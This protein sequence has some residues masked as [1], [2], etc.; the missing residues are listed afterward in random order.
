[1]CI[2]TLNGHPRNT[3]IGTNVLGVPI[4]QKTSIKKCPT[5]PAGRPLVLKMDHLMDAFQPKK[6]SVIFTF[7]VPAQFYWTR[8]HEVSITSSS[9]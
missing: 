6:I 2:E 3:Q 9:Q 8:G 4:L 5:L 1:M 7:R